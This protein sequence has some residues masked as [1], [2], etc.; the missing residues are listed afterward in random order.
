KDDIRYVPT[1]EESQARAEAVT[2]EQIRKLYETQV[3]AAKA[4]LAVVGDFDPEATIAK[5]QDI[6]KGWES[7]VPVRRIDRKSATDRPGLREDIGTADK[8]NAVYV[9]ALAF[10]LKDSDPDFAAL[11]LGNFIL[12]GGTLSSRLGDRIRQ[13]EGLSYGVTS[14]FSAGTQD[15]V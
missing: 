7:K 12:G 14:S 6:L 8:A 9:A 11:R 10:P 5:V 2:I 15:A 13:K 4:E 1:I 3:G